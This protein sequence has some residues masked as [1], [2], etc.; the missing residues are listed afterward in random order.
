MYI[1]G[2][3]HRA[4]VVAWVRM[5]LHRRGATIPGRLDD[6]RAEFERLIEDVGGHDPATAELGCALHDLGMIDEQIAFRERVRRQ[7]VGVAERPQRERGREAAVFAVPD[8]VIGNRIRAVVS[9][10]VPDSLTALELQQYCSTRVPKYMIPEVIDLC[11]ELPKTST[12]KIDRVRLAQQA[13]AAR[14][15]PSTAGQ[16]SLQSVS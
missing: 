15:V 8:E 13:V 1:A 5:E 7:V 11:D 16:Q 10:H 3:E 6:A 2:R 9:A 12:G 4:P 14:Q